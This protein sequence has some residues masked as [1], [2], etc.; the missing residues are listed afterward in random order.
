MRFNIGTII[1]FVL[2]LSALL[3]N[4]WRYPQVREMFAQETSVI[5]IPS[6]LPLLQSNLNNS[7]APNDPV[8]P[9]QL[10]EQDQTDE[11]NKSD[12]LIQQPY[13]NLPTNL[14]IVPAENIE[15][16]VTPETNYTPT[17]EPITPKIENPTNNEPLPEINFISEIPPQN[18]L[19]NNISADNDSAD[20]LQLNIDPRYAIY[21][22][23][24]QAA[25][26]LDAPNPIIANQY[27]PN[28]KQT[29]TTIKQ[30]RLI[31]TINTTLER[32]VIYD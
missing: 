20:L 3:V 16:N 24:T 14:P 19:L 32:S 8:A 22:H 23:N 27:S 25:A 12:D 4:I 15:K 17:Q 21:S 13:N 5:V 11:T 10:E 28:T 26:K 29:S 9:N 31:N 7:D 6:V 1:S 2:L 18:L 30:N